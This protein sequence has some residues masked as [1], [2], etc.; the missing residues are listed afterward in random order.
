M[1]NPSEK[2]AIRNTADLLCAWLDCTSSQIFKEQ[3]INTNQLKG[4]TIDAIIKIRNIDFLIEYKKFGDA[5]SV[6]NGIRQLNNINAN[7]KNIIKTLV[8]P[9][10]HELG[11]K[12]CNE[13][14]LSWLDLSG[15]ANI[16]GPGIRIIIE[17]Q[18]NLYKRP[19]RS[20]SVFAPKA[21]RVAR[22]LLYN[23]TEAFS[24]REISK[25]TNLGE[26]YVSKIVNSLV[27]LNLIDRDEEG[28]VT[29]Q[30]PVTLLDAWLE[31]YSFSKHNS[32]SGYIPARSGTSLI[33]QI[34]DSLNDKGVDF[35]VSGLGAAWLY[36]HFASFRT[37][38]VYIN[39][40]INSALLSSLDFSEADVGSN[41]IIAS[42]NDQSIFWDRKEIEGIQCVHPIQVF[43]DLKGQ[44]ERAQEAMLELKTYLLQSYL[45]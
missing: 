1:D 26:G 21:S 15:N 2:E 25:K 42:P 44:P 13:A 18:P 43:L 9:Y 28:N 33:Q 37:I 39:G 40:N 20:S 23:R 19:G 6:K 17:N 29:I 31:K 5:S 34:N 16:T 3:E 10:M 11:R 36:T 32:I 4:Y 45:R 38:T 22:F 27:N 35:A 41:T 8:V 14:N 30:D 12:Y 7:K 24:Q